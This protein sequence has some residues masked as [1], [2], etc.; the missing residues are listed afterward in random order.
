MECFAWYQTNCL[1]IKH[2]MCC[3]KYIIL[4][5]NSTNPLIY[6]KSDTNFL[7]NDTAKLKQQQK[8]HSQNSNGI[9]EIWCLD[10]RFASYIRKVIKFCVTRRVFR[11]AFRDKCEIL[12][13]LYWWKVVSFQKKKA[14]HIFWWIFKLLMHIL[15][16]LFKVLELLL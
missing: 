13:V 10:L 16:Y 8:F 5:K 7:L 11:R 15:K 6:Q 4:C 9:S 1:T 2:K 3:Y 12:R 14:F